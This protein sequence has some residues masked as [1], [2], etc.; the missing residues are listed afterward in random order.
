MQTNPHGADSR[1]SYVERQNLPM[2]M[3]MRLFNRLTN[4]FSKKIANHEAAIAL[5][6]MYYNFCR[7]HKTLRLTPAMEAGLTSHVW[8]VAE[9]V[10]L[11]DK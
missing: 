2:R 7:V 11:L 1:E 8:D 3:S 4:A 9:L 10:S 5:H 6:F